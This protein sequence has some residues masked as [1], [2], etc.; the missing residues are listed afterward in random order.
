MHHGTH[1]G[2]GNIGAFLLGALAATA[3][4]GY[5]LYGPHGAEHRKTVGKWVKSA[6]AE[7]LKR[8]DQIQDVTEEQYGKIV[9][10]VTDRYSAMAEVGQE[11]ASQ[12]SAYFKRQWDKMRDAARRAKE[13]AEEELF[14]ERLA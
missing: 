12:A 11:K 14:F 1:H 13:E 7:I 10:E 4:G 3:I 2:G 9:D 8:M 5:F 6:K